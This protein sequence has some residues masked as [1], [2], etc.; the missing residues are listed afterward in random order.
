MRLAALLVLFASF[1]GCGGRPAPPAAGGSSG[2]AAGGPDAPAVDASRIVAIGGAV[3]E[4]VYAL[5]LGDQV[6]G[7]DR[8]SVYPGEILGKPRLNYFRQTS[9][10]GVLSLGP[11]L[12]LATDEAGPPG[13]LGQI[14]AA[15]VP[16]VTVSTPESVGGAAGRVR[17]LGRALGRAAQ[18][19]SVVA[20]ME[21]QLAEAGRLRPSAPPRV[22]FVYARG[23]GLVQVFGAGT[24]ADLVLRLAGAVNAAGEVDGNVPLTAEA[25]AVARPDVVVIPSRSLESLGGAGGLFAQPGLAQTPAG[26]ARRVVAVDDALLLGLGPRLGEGVA[27]LARGL[28]ETAGERAPSTTARR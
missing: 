17:E 12:V 26:A 3:T 2:T 20:Q 11:T 10:E 22:L 16:V 14:R 21:R 23:A 8:S 13:V 4:T 15:G 27:A 28:A 18:A 19:D 5:G 1:A 25:V 24:P 6:V 9:A 7:T